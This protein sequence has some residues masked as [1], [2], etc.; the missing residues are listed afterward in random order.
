M[1]R[2]SLFVRYL[3]YALLYAGFIVGMTYVL[4]GCTTQDDY[5]RKATPQIGE[6]LNG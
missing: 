2:Y 3:I 4:S 6:I 5:W 1:M